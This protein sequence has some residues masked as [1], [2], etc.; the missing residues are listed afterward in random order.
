MIYSL[1]FMLILKYLIYCNNHLFK[2]IVFKY[3]IKKGGQYFGG[4]FT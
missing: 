1:I 3:R 2:E 4:K